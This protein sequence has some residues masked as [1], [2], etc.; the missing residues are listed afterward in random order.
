MIFNWQFFVDSYLLCYF[1]L[2][3]KQTKGLQ[4]SGSSL[5]SLQALGYI[6][7]SQILC[8]FPGFRSLKVTVAEPELFALCFQDY[9]ITQGLLTQLADPT[10]TVFCHC[11]FHS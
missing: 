9:K 11:L 8:N 10:E 2:A 3:R 4:F 7:S 6:S 5:Y 1:K